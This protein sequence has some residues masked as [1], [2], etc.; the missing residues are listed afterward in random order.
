MKTPEPSW[1]PA[2]RASRLRREEGQKYQ[3]LPVGVALFFGR[4]PEE[5]YQPQPVMVIG[6]DIL[7]VIPPAGDMIDGIPVTGPEG[8]RHGSNV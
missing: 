8:A 4:T 6:K 2:V 7:P 1:N 3:V 5:R